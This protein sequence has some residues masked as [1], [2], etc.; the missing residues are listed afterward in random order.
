MARN[1]LNRAMAYAAAGLLLFQ[2]IVTVFSCARG[3]PSGLDVSFTSPDHV[4]SWNCLGGNSAG[5][6]SDVA[7]APRHD[8]GPLKDSAHG[9]AVC[10][11]LCHQTAIAA[12]SGAPVVLA[13]TVDATFPPAPGD[14]RPGVAPPLTSARDPPFSVIA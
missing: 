1:R 9:C 3:F 6:V 11:S 10:L 12:A 13:A 2:V 5:D 8:G 7:P 14:V 4:V